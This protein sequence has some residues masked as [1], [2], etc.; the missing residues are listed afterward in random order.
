[1]QYMRHLYPSAS[2]H[3]SRG[4]LFSELPIICNEGVYVVPRERARM[5]GGRNAAVYSVFESFEDTAA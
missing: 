5:K 2:V 3:P 4:N 1:M